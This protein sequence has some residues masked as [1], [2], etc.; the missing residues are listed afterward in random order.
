MISEI[1][2]QLSANCP[3]FSGRIEDAITAGA[4]E[5]SL[6]PLAVVY[7]AADSVT[8]TS[9]SCLLIRRQWSVLIMA[10]GS[11]QLESAITDVINALNDFKPSGCI[12]SLIFIGGKLEQIE[13]ATLQWSLIF[14]AKIT[15]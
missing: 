5:R 15:L 7:P 11:M 4:L 2:A 13:N 10:N 8:E 3:V 12:S 1:M 14:E 9:L 6:Y